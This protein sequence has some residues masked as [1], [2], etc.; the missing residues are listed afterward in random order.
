[1]S[2][3]RAGLCGVARGRHRRVCVP[4][5]GEHEGRDRGR[6]RAAGPRAR[7]Q[8]RL[9]R[10]ARPRRCASSTFCCSSS[11]LSWMCMAGN[12]EVQ[13]TRVLADALPGV[14]GRV[15][16]RHQRVAQMRV[17]LM[18][19]YAEIAARSGACWR[20]PKRGRPWRCAHSTCCN[21]CTS[22]AALARARRC[23]GAHLSE[24]DV[25]VCDAQHVC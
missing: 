20:V 16:T 15:G 9:P 10:R 6:G 21:A 22:N 5:H 25:R 11:L 13:R 17:W 24:P 4:R 12:V 19:Q 18:W 23:V 8:R 3:L 7:A 14:R 1:M 2:L